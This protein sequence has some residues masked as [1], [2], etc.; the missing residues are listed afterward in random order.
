MSNPFKFLFRNNHHILK[1]TIWTPE[2]LLEEYPDCEYN[3]HGAKGA[4]LHYQWLTNEENICNANMFCGKNAMIAYTQKAKEMQGSRF[5]TMPPMYN[6]D[7]VPMDMSAFVLK[8]E[9]KMIY[10]KLL[11]KYT[12][13][14]AFN[15]L[16]SFCDFF[17]CKEAI[18]G[19]LIA[20]ELQY[21]S[22]PHHFR[23]PISLFSSKTGSFSVTT[24]MLST[25]HNIAYNYNIE[26]NEH[27]E[28]IQHKKYGTYIGKIPIR[29]EEK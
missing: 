20:D 24:P 25:M 8:K 12:E 22:D 15:F 10:E 7:C 14:Q 18:D 3:A 21:S 26:I 17:V 4:Y 9:V 6:L 5:I 19:L 27:G 1:S 2:R 28:E 13:K 16:K 29:K 11:H 23:L